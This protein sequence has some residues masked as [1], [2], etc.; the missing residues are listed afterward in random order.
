M[1]DC[2]SLIFQFAF[3]KFE[4]FKNIRTVSKD[5]LKI[6]NLL[7]FQPVEPLY[8]PST[9]IATNT[10]TVC[11]GKS[12]RNKCVPYGSFP[13]PIYIY[14]DNFECNRQVIRNL[15]KSAST[16]DISILIKEA[17]IQYGKCPR[18][19]GSVSECMFM[20]GWMWKSGH[21]RCLIGN[22]LKDVHLDNISKLYKQQYK[23]LKL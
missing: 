2:W 16:C 5:F 7:W 6:A 21:I 20:Q 10:C 12:S 13:R 15:V 17:V 14:C 23:I 22:F 9:F 19:D 1:Q 11:S 18:S 3:C 8:A 4:D